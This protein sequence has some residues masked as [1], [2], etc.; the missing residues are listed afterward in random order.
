MAS[1]IRMQIL[2]REKNFENE[3]RMEVLI[4]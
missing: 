3:H 2:I 4:K 1:I